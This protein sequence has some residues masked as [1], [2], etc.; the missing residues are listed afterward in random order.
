MF[1]PSREPSLPL[2]ADFY[3]DKVERTVIDVLRKEVANP[4]RLVTYVKAYNEA[5]RNL[6]Q[7]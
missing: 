3:L 2:S 1:G 4:N 5:R 7:R 6:P